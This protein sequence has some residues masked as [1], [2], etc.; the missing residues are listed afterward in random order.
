VKDESVGLRKIQI[1]YTNREKVNSNGIDLQGKTK[2]D[3]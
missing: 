2:V 1:P 3:K